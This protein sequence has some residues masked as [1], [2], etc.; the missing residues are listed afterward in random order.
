MRNWRAH[1]TASLM[2]IAF[3]ASSL[4]GLRLVDP[5]SSVFGIM[6]W[7]T[8]M[9]LSLVYVGYAFYELIRA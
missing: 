2:V 9:G 6:K 4:M 8:L 5:A 3:V 1:K 7:S